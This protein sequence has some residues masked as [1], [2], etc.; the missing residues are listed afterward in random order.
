MKSPC[1]QPM[2]QSQNQTAPHPKTWAKFPPYRS[3][4]R[5][6]ENGRR[7]WRHRRSRW[8]WRRRRA[9]TPRAQGTQR[10]RRRGPGRRRSRC[11]R[12]AAPRA[13]PSARRSGWAGG[14]GGISRVRWLER[15]RRRRARDGR[16]REG[17]GSVYIERGH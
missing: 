12:R 13:P 9:G 16:A 17:N 15:R 5:A 10:T 8:A 6:P 4:T 11:P 1:T 2:K 3:A 14:G 7:R